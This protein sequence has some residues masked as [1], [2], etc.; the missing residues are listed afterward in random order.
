MLIFCLLAAALI[1][2]KLSGV[3][4]N[5]LYLVEDCRYFPTL[6]DVHFS[7]TANHSE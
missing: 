1:L 6:V 2:L 3:Q 5:F 7:Q 4:I